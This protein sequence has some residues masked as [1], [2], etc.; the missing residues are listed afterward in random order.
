[1]KAE[2][3][4]KLI[5]AT[6]PLLEHAFKAYESGWVQRISV[7]LN[8]QKIIINDAEYAECKKK[9]HTLLNEGDYV[10]SADIYGAL[11]CL[12]WL[13]GQIR[14]EQKEVQGDEG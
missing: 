8:C 4:V 9:K 5:E 1:M 13:L 7:C 6:L 12:R 10:P 11:L 14:D 2:R 3:L